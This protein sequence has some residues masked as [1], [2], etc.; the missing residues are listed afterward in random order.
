M[1][2]LD[3]HEYIAPESLLRV[4]QIDPYEDARWEALVN[5]HPD[6]LIYHHPAWLRVLEEAFG[7]K[8]FHLGCEDARG[9]LRGILPLFATHGLFTGY[10]YSSLPRTPIGGTLALD[11]N[12]QSLL[13]QAAIQHTS[14]NAGAQLQIKVQ[15]DELPEAVVD[16]LVGGPWRETYVVDLP[17]RPDP[18]HIGNTRSHT[19]HIRWAIHQAEQQGIEVQLAETEQE[20]RAWYQVYLETMRK[21]CVPPRPY[22]FFQIAWHHLKARGLLWLLVAKR[23]QGGHSQIVAGTLYLLFGQTIFCAYNGRSLGDT[24]LHSNDAI[25]WRAIH[26]AYAGGF[27]Y[28]DL[29][30]V[31]KGNTGLATFKS[32]W[33]AEVRLLYRY[34]CPTPREVAINVLE[35]STPIHRLGNWIWQKLPLNATVLLSTWGHHWF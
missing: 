26:D 22:R 27:R 29:G 2:A 20:L 7:Y 10:M 21:V 30:E 16:E 35:S 9:Q 8:P 28:Y 32:K 3:N 18:L 13:L 31:S 4:F 19:H 14:K 24:S 34:Y 33:G 1:S 15:T 12:A 23:S 11:D 17:E 6:A 5:A 25:H